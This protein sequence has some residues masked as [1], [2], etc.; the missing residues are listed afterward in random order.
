VEQLLGPFATLIPVVVLLS[1]RVGAA[2]ALLPAPFGDMAPV[3]VR[4]GL[5]LVIAIV[6]GVPH[7]E[8]LPAIDLEPLALGRAAI[9]EL[10][11]GAAL[12]F[13]ARGTLAAAEI[14]GSF[15]SF[16]MGLGFAQSVDPMFGEQTA[17]PGRLISSFAALVFLIMQGHHIVVSAL[18][19]SV[20][21]APPGEVLGAIS[22]E[23][24]IEVGSVMMVQGLRI[25]APIVATLFIVHLGTGLVGRAAPKVQLFALTF[26]I[27]AAAGTLILVTAAPSM[28]SAIG[29]DVS[30]L[31]ERMMQI[32][33]Q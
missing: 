6:V 5:T 2:I 4:A 27:A 28:A 22:S 30:R 15:A 17:P 32:L 25:A 21:R 9:G 26:A 24:I 29:E 14:A 8:T 16:S 10:M 1:L 23:S 33:P 20:G 18:A 31:P 11:V 3:T 13:T 19:A 7:I 12:G